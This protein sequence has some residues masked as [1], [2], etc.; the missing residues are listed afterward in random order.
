MS[1]AG[2]TT[3]EGECAR[4]HKLVEVTETTLLDHPLGVMGAGRALH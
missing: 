2:T 1:G 4:L 3:S